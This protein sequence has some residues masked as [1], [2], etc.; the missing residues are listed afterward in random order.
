MKLPRAVRLARQ[1]G[2]PL[3]LGGAHKETVG[4]WC[5]HKQHDGTSAHSEAKHR[6]D[7]AFRKKTVERRVMNSETKPIH[8]MTVS[9][10]R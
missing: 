1:V 10:P 6:D 5:L 2:R 8:D 7:V 3:G 9:L 4:R